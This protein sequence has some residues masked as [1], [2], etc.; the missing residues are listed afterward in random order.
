M[1]ALRNPRIALHARKG[2]RAS[3]IARAT[4]AR[5]R[6]AEIMPLIES[7]QQGGITTLRGIAEALN[8]CGIPAPRGGSWSAGQ[9]SRVLAP[10]SVNK[11]HLLTSFSRLPV[12]ASRYSGEINWRSPSAW[13]TP[14][15]QRRSNHGNLKM[16]NEVSALR[17]AHF[18][19]TDSLGS[20][21]AE[22]DEAHN[23]EPKAAQSLS[24]LWGVEGRPR[25]ARP[26]T[27]LPKEPPSP[28]PPHWIE[29]QSPISRLGD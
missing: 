18:A 9:V 29:S 8:L 6:A 4:A 3:A 27:R 20:G 22:S 2:T 26:W 5:T 16:A 10:G 13:A 24:S 14:M 11:N 25:D 7:F 28:A 21:E 1:D 23:A 19:Q 15:E 12:V 17:Q